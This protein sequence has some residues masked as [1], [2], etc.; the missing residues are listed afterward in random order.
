MSPRMATNSSSVSW[1][2]SLRT[3]T[4]SPWGGSLV[5]GAFGASLICWAAVPFALRE[6]TFGADISETA[7]LRLSVVVGMTSIGESPLVRKVGNVCR[8][9]SAR[10]NPRKHWAD[11]HLFVDSRGDGRPSALIRDNSGTRGGGPG[12]GWW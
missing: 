7:D 1:G 6:S 11:D 8:S 4:F 3:T 10:G 9:S 5:R 2:G 12:D